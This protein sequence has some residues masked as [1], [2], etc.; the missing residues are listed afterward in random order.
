[1]IAG[2]RELLAILESVRES[3]HRPGPAYFAAADWCEERGL[4]ALARG[5]RRMAAEGRVPRR[6]GDSGWAWD[7]GGDGTP[8][9][10]ESVRP[11][12]YARLVLWGFEEAAASRLAPWAADWLPGSYATF[13]GRS[14][15][16]T[17][18]RAAL[19]LAAVYGSGG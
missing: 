16:P 4:D 19:A 17:F 8:P 18:A 9:Y 3:P 6:A 14:A 10:P 2:H 5:L 12:D 15:F 13:S 1:M 11:P 7:K